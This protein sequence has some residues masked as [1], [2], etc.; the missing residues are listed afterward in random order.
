VTASKH[1][2]DAEAALRRAPPCSTLHPAAGVVV[3]GVPVAPPVPLPA[4]PPATLFGLP[5]AGRPPLALAVA[6]VPEA[7]TLPSIGT[8]WIPRHCASGP[9]GSPSST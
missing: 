8:Q 3:A 7:A 1:S 5:P 4:F 9:H 2:S 6:L